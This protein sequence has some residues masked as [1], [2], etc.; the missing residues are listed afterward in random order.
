MFNL[1]NHPHF[2]SWV[3]PKSG[4]ES[5]IL[6]K[7][8][9]PVQQSF[10]FTNSGISNNEQWLWFYTAF[11]PNKQRTL[12]AVSLDPDNPEIKLFPQA[13]FTSVSPLVAPENDGVYFC[14]GASVYKLFLDGSTEIICTVPEDFIGNRQFNRISTHL[15]ISADKKHLLLDGDLGD[16]WWVGTADLKTGKFTL[17]K[18]FGCHHNHAQFST[19][20]PDLL[21]IPEDWWFDKSSGKN[22]NLDHRLWL[23][24]LQQTRY[25]IVSPKNWDGD[26]TSNASHEWWSQ[27]G[28]LCWN[29]YK[30]GTFECD[31]TTLESKNIWKKPLCHAHCNS[32][33][34][35]WCADESPYKWEQTPVEI[36]FYDREKD[37]EVQIVSAM[38][39]PPMHRNTYHL[40][41]HPQFSPQDNF[42]SYTTMV[43][44]CVDVAVCPIAP[45]H[46]L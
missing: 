45:L 43:N 26:K 19:T 4:A 9:A 31:P 35:L 25:E 46:D 33:R 1:K 42:I 16:F 11:P 41:P 8:V 36:L 6:N 2:K 23:M 14:M 13:G 15:S 10:Y 22:F 29:D 21:V 34:T 44:G 17:L 7:R 27:D 24:N 37:K 12:A 18:E 20:D 38:P 32:D 28:Y 3:D 5:F 30:L 40:D 39:K